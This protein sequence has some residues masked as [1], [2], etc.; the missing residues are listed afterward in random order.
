[1]IENELDLTQNGEN[2]EEHTPTPSEDVTLEEEPTD[3]KQESDETGIDYEALAKED[4]ETLKREFPA[5]HDLTTLLE[6][7]QPE[8]YGELRDLGLSPREAYLATNT[9]RSERRSYDNR[10]H[11][12]SSVPK[13]HGGRVDAMSINELRE[14]REL[15]SGMSDSE[16][17]RLYKKV[18]S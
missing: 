3:V 4:L 16:I 2:D 15:F 17:V 11:L 10:S 18:N 14:A 7:E 13:S 8:R 9:Q 12:H 6:L 5:L 1:M